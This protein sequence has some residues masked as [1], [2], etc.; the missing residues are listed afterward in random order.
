[1]FST[2]KRLL[3]KIAALAVALRQRAELCSRATV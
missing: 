2:K 3:S 1:M